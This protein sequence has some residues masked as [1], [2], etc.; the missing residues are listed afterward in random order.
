VAIAATILAAEARRSRNP[1]YFSDRGDASVGAQVA[2]LAVSMK[3]RS[4][5]PAR[6]QD[7]EGG[8]SLIETVVAAGIVAGAFAG[9]AHVFALS[10]AHN[11]AARDGSAAMVLAAQKM[12]Q[13][14]GLI[15][16]VDLNEGG[17]LASSVDGFADYLDQSGNVLAAGASV[18]PG[19][20]YVRRWSVAAMPS[21]PDLLVIQVLVT[22]LAPEA[23]VDAATVIT[24]R[25]RRAPRDQ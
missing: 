9:L 1:A 19:T 13:V 18:P 25:S 11:V 22:K 8:F 12:E 23:V 24:L 4:R 17:T 2:H 15:P 6:D 21:K 7:E 20:V 10:I 5:T 14:R 16:G 3:R